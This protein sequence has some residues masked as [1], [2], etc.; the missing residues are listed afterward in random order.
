MKKF[1][2]NEMLGLKVIRILITDIRMY[3][4]SD[5][6]I[7]SYNEKKGI[8]RQYIGTQEWSHEDT[9]QVWAPSVQIERNSDVTSLKLMWEIGRFSVV[10]E[11]LKISQNQQ[12]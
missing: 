4:S 8:E 9:H 2:Q 3:L 10:P 11:T 7:F 12:I 1:Q 6:W 5:I